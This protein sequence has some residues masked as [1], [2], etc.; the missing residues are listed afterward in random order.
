M[1]YEYVDGVTLFDNSILD[2]RYNQYVQEVKRLQ[3][4]NLPVTSG[5]SDY[6]N[7]E[8][9]DDTINKN[10]LNQVPGAMTGLGILGTFIG[11]SFG[12]QAFNTGTAEEITQ[13][14]PELMDGIKV[15]FHTSIYGMIFSL[16]FNYIYRK[17]LQ[18]T[19]GEM[20]RFLETYE[21]C[22][23][24]NLENDIMSQI[25][26]R[27]NE[28][29]AFLGEVSTYITQ[30]LVEQLNKILIPELQSIRC[31]TDTL[32]KEFAAKMSET[33]VPEIRE[34]SNKF[35]DFMTASTNNQ[36]EGISV[37]INSF[38]NS[39]NAAVNTNFEELNRALERTTRVQ[40]E[41]CNYLENVLQRV[42]Q[43]TIDLEALNK[44]S[45]STITETS[46]IVES[47]HS[48]NETIRSWSEKATDQLSINNELL[49]NYS[50]ELEAMKEYHS[51]VAANTETV[52]L[53]IGE[54]IEV[55]ERSRATMASETEKQIK[56][57]SQMAADCTD[58]M[59]DNIARAVDDNLKV[60]MS[61]QS[62]AFEAMEKEIENIRLL[63]ESSEAR[64]AESAEKY[65]NQFTENAKYQLNNL[66]K[67]NDGIHNDIGEATKALK[68][69]IKELNTGLEESIEKTFMS[70]DE[71][72][73]E[74][75]QHLSGT[76]A[77]IDSTTGRVPEVVA[78]AYDGMEESF[79][80]IQ[81]KLKML[82]ESL[83]EY[84]EGIQKI[85][86]MTNNMY[87]SNHD[88]E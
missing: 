24:P 44:I 34:V 26:K 66:F 6:I 73:S 54:Q 77:Q 27:Q 1:H 64:M 9:I 82:T 49:A 61:A 19:Y 4:N 59:E 87:F 53:K 33:I 80:T 3:E 58:V 16:V 36:L 10:L 28:Q 50:E 17:I 21:K 67:T 63:A 76:I 39:M 56:T 45:A 13:S 81:S 65:L 14:I 29:T 69:T 71:N 23:T 55:L 38:I 8:L 52:L 47:I 85:I 51:T 62:G 46:V 30:V 57:I 41:Q 60:L 22:V 79:E 31:N 18:D 43:L 72:L 88:N 7:D 74:I 68:K 5:I 35:D 86:E 75:V 2:E 32:S 37:M 11:L 15:A 78:S 40:N 42:G 25:L 83:S 20:H 70:F 84:Q 12:L 48:T